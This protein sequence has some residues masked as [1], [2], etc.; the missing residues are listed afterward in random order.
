MLSGKIENY[1]LYAFGEIILIVVG[2]LIAWQINDLNEIKKNRVVQL[3]IYETLYEELNTNL[4]VLDNA[5]VRYNENTLALQNALTYVG[6]DP[7]DLNEEARDQIIKI[8]FRNTKLRVEALSSINSSD[9]FQ[10]LENDSLTELIAQYPT[11]LKSYENQEIKIRNIVDNR[12]KPVLEEHISLIDLLPEKN[13]KYDQIRATGQK[14]N[15]TDL[16]N[17]KE[18]QNAVIDQLLQIQIQLNIGT[19]LRNITETLAIKLL[20]ELGKRRS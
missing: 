13:R 10:F 11:E 20:Q 19:N 2:I 16:L 18:Y 4:G 14:S 3:K 8:K 6:L 12:L 5:I 17:S 9:K 7:G 15:Y 1:L